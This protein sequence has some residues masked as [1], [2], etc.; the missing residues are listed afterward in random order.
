MPDTARHIFGISSS[1]CSSSGYGPN[2]VA[3]GS[4]EQDARQLDVAVFVRCSASLFLLQVKKLSEALIQSF[5]VA[6]SSK[7]IAL[8]G[9]LS[10]QVTSSYACQKVG[11]GC[12]CHYR[13]IGDHLEF[14]FCSKGIVHDT[15]LTGVRAPERLAQV[16]RLSA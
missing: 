4:L 7:S 9:Y 6:C 1:A 14:E 10:L 13:G 2:Y 8:I 15:I 12:Q 16:N 11:T 3:V 5:P